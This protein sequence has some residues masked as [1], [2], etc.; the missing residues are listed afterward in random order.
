V[1]GA[2]LVLGSAGCGEPAPPG[3]SLANSPAVLPRDRW[4]VLLVTLDTTRADRLGCYGNA[5]I[6]TPRL[7]ALAAQGA[8]FATAIATVPTTL[9]SHASILTGRYPAALG[10]HDNGL[11]T[12]PPAEQTLAESLAAAGW[13]TGAFVSAFVLD[14][15]FGLAQGFGTYD[16]TVDLPYDHRATGDAVTPEPGA[17]P[18]ADAVPAGRHE[19]IEQLGGA[20]QRRG[21]ATTDAA[22]TWLAARPPTA[23]AAPAGAPWMLWVHYY[24][25]HQPYDAPEPF[26]TR[27]DP[28]YRGPLDGDARTFWSVHPGGQPDTVPPA[29][30]AHMI[31]RHDGE[32][33]FVDGCVGRL[34]DAIEARGE[35]A[36]TLVVVTADH[37]EGFGE[38]RQ[39]WQHSSELFEEAVR[40]P[41]IVRHP[42]GLGAGTAPAELVSGVDVT[43]TILDAVGL[44]APPRTDGRSLL[45]GLAGASGAN[46]SGQAGATIRGASGAG[47]GARDAV[48]LEA[49]RKAQVWPEP[50]SRLGWRTPRHKLIAVFDEHERLLRTELYDLLADP[51]ERHPL[52]AE[53][54]DIGEPLVRALTELHARIALPDEALPRRDADARD[55]EALK[56]LGYVGEGR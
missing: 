3:P 34:L 20:F 13:D 39:I 35:A 47:S 52:G 2:L 12:L 26:T 41:L 8:R 42:A 21:D 28:G 31:A 51:G 38:H 37:G 49:K 11:Y 29:D 15:Q 17:E 22:L 43:P 44:A 32:V 30:I 55:T 23:A 56:A 24:D 19:L 48:L 4:N 53:G 14:A 1:A 27:Y 54:R 33:A 18:P 5:R 40:V 50:R 7:D 9:P 6:E 25:P 16:D 46:I 45:P 10:V 36:R